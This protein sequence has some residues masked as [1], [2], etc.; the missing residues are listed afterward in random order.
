[1]FGIC[2]VACEGGVLGDGFDFVVA[3]NLGDGLGIF[4]VA[5]GAGGDFLDEVAGGFGNV[6]VGYG[7]ADDAG[8]ENALFGKGQNRGFLGDGGGALA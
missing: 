3:F 1:M 7:G 6:K 4:S 8:K 2:A 5:D